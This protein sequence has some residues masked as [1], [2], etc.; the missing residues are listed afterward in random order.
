MT[1][2]L[3]YR[4]FK[5]WFYVTYKMKPYLTYTVNKSEGLNTMSRVYFLRMP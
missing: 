3:L 5:T 1:N 4:I 2:K